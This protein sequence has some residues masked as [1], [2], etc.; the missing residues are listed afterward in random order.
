MVK[1]D[2]ALLSRMSNRQRDEGGRFR[3][4][5]QTQDILKAFDA[6]DAPFLT[7]G[8]LADAVGVANSTINQRLNR[9]HEAGLVDR[10]KTGAR[11][12]GWWATVAPRLSEESIARV[13]RRREQVEHGEVVALDDL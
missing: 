5:I 6:A 10:K 8:E 1:G 3:E 13:E 11:S 9:M 12:V 2:N 4:E 7:A